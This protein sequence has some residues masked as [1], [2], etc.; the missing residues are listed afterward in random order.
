MKKPLRSSGFPKGSDESVFSYTYPPEQGKKDDEEKYRE[1]H[2]YYPKELPRHRS[3]P[4]ED[5]M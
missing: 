3:L 4:V 1:H 2:L 5:V